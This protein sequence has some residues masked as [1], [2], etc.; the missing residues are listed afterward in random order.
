[1]SDNLPVKFDADARLKFLALYSVTGQLQHSAR[2]AGV[3]PTTV[4]E[5]KKKDPHFLAAFTEAYE[6]FKESLEAEAYRR[7]FIGVD[8]PV[9]QRGE[10]VGQIREYDSAILQMYLKRHVPEYKESFTIDVN[11]NPAP[12]VVPTKDNET[13]WEKRHQ[14]DAD[15]E[16]LKEEQGKNEEQE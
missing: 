16:T 14:V 9:F 13:E 6:D 3:S 11:V 7:A 10:E 12:L 2:Q 8:R 1:M 15:F 4:R 5:H